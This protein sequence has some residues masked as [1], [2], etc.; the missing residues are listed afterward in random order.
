MKFLG[1]TNSQLHIIL[2]KY[3]MRW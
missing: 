3:L 2:C 1:L